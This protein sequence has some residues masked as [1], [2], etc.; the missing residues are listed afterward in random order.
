MRVNTPSEG[1]TRTHDHEVAE[2]Q[3]QKRPKVEAAKKA[4]LSMLTEERNAMVR[5]FKIA[6]EEY[7]TMDN[8]DDDPQMD[9]RVDYEDPWNGEDQLSGDS[10]P[11]A[12]W[13]DVDPSVHPPAPPAWIDRL[14][15]SVELQGLCNMSVLM[16]EED[17]KE[18][19]HSKLTTRFVYDWRLKDYKGPKKMTNLLSRSGFEE[20]GVLQGNMHSL[21]AMKIPLHLQVQHMYSIFCPVSDCR[22]LLT[23]KLLREQ[24]PV[25]TGSSQPS[26]MSKTP[27][28]GPT[29]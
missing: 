13:S 3:S 6:E 9:D 14:A 7:Y 24:I 25:V 2:E 22:R 28:D 16:K 12:L 1:T 20:V 5:V 8:Y 17:Y 18:P 21:S 27:F 4:R 19:V 15:D 29:A 26:M 23:A 11:E 10:M